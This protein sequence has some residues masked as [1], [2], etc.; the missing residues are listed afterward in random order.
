M[1]PFDTTGIDLPIR[2][3]RYPWSRNIWRSCS[4]TSPASP[5]LPV[6]M[7]TSCPRA[8]SSLERKWTCSL[9]PPRV[10]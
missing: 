9:T 1:E 2:R 6:T 7:V 4:A 10:G 8:A 3:V 5:M